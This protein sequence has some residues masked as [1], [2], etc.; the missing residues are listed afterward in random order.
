MADAVNASSYHR[1]HSGVK[2]GERELCINHQLPNIFSPSSSPG[3]GFVKI[4]WNASSPSGMSSSRI[5]MSTF[6]YLSPLAK[7]RIW[8]K[9]Q[10]WAVLCFNTLVFFKCLEINTTYC[11]MWNKLFTGFFPYFFY[12]LFFFQLTILSLKSSRKKGNSWLSSIRQQEKRQK[13]FSNIKGVSVK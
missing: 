4:S 10:K 6:L 5:M 7:W 9:R 11:W 2:G 3:E 13:I 12:D 1:A 8:Y